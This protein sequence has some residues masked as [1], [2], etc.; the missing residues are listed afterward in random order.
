[1]E[2]SHNK[3]V[4]ITCGPTG[5]PID[6]MRIISNL[7]S[8]SLGQM[9]AEDFIKAGAKV[10]LLEG[11]VT[12]FIDLS[13]GFSY[14]DSNI[15]DGPTFCRP[16]WYWGWVCFSSSHD[17]TNLNYGGGLGIRW[18]INRDMFM[19]ASYSIMKVDISNTS[20]PEFAMGR[21]EFG[22]RY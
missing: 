19:R 13:I 20:D 4:L 17:D 2:D 7:S 21:L 5:V 6:T 3:K 22:W 8:G 1:M 10:T 18:D 14:T 12:P 9:I 11:P 16:D 15:Q